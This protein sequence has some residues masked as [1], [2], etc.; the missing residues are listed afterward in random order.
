MNLIPFRT[1]LV[2][3]MAGK[4][5]LCVA[6]LTFSASSWAANEMPGRFFPGKYFERKAQFYLQKRDY[7][8]A[9]EMFQ[10]AGF[11][12]NK[13]AQYN[14]GIMYFN[15]IGDIP[16]DK[17]RGVAWLGIAAE[18]HSQLADEA[19]H[20]A[21]AD[22][23]KANEIFDA[24]NAKYGDDLT[25]KRA[26]DHFERER[27]N[28][29][30]SHVGSVGVLQVTEYGENGAN[31]S[32][33]ATFYRD[34]DRQFREYVDS[35]FGHVNVGALEPIAMPANAKAKAS[36]IPLATPQSSAPIK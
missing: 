14:V 1:R 12:A 23:V 7:K 4:L 22:R 8:A 21:Y 31:T 30:G 3:R 28:V 36:T 19:L 35:M 11:W 9:L 2:M 6:V 27:R 5:V 25:L 16:V 32:I 15:G 13:V 34:M 24:L 18:Q 26:M 17:V 33:G 29:T 20:A 10:L